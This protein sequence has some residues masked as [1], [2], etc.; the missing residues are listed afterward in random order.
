MEAKLERAESR[1]EYEVNEVQSYIA[2]TLP[3]TCRSHVD[4]RL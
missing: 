4:V 1:D 2:D 3:H